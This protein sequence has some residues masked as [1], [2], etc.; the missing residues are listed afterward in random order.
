MTE[1]WNSVEEDSKSKQV[2]AT[3]VSKEQPHMGVMRKGHTGVSETDQMIAMNTGGM[4]HSKT[5]H[6]PEHQRH[7]AKWRRP[8]R[9]SVRRYWWSHRNPPWAPTGPTQGET[10]LRKSETR[11]NDG[12]RQERHRARGA[13]MRR[14][15]TTRPPQRNGG[16]HAQDKDRERQQSPPQKRTRPPPRR[17]E[18]WNE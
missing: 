4:S 3:Q 5:K 1:S 9:T 13:T 15:L 12:N 6:Q 17:S 8:T 7:P 14:D 11:T 2:H 16:G 10:P 18:G